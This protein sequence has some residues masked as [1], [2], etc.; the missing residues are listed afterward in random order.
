MT[1]GIAALS[2][3]KFSTIKSLQTKLMCMLKEAQAVM[4]AFRTLVR[5]TA[6]KYLMVGQEEQVVM[7]ILEQALGYK[8]CTNY[9]ELILK[10]ILENQAKEKKIMEPM[11]KT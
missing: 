8:T 9:E 3:L 2:S 6:V 10:E 7:F 1:V 5:T 4:V 11:P